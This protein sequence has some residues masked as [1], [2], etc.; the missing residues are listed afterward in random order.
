MLC[1]PVLATAKHK[2][3]YKS[4]QSQSNSLSPRNL[5]LRFTNETQTSHLTQIRS[6]IILG[7]V[8]LLGLA[9]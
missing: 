4:K 7:I 6:N 3:E 5:G 2:A 1:E 9:G 8:R